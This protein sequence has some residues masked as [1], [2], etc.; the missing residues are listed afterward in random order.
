VKNLITTVMAL[1]LVIK[2]T[3]GINIRVTVIAT[4]ITTL[5]IIVIIIIK[6]ITMSGT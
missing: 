2:A 1:F 3:R 5:I 6:M 4:I